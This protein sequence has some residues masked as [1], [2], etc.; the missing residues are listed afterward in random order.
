MVIIPKIGKYGQMPLKKNGACGYFQALL[1][2][3]PVPLLTKARQ[4]NKKC[5]T[6]VFESGHKITVYLMK[7]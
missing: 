5:G 4:G 3:F 7:T 2:M 1:S 6:S